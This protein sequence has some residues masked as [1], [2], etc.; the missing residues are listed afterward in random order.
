[1]KTTSTFVVARKQQEIRKN[2]HTVNSF[3]IQ[4]R[5]RSI[6]RNLLTKKP[7]LRL[8][9]L[10]LSDLNRGAIIWGDAIQ[11]KSNAFS[12]LID[13]AEAQ[14]IET[15]VYR[16]G[17][18][19]KVPYDYLDQSREKPIVLVI[20]DVEDIGTEGYR[21]LVTF[22][23]AY[24]RKAKV[25]PVIGINSIASTSTD[26]E[27]FEFSCSVMSHIAFNCDEKTANFVSELCGNYSLGTKKLTSSVLTTLPDNLFYLF[28]AGHNHPILGEIK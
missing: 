27:L 24:A 22:N 13:S 20:E 16:K 25:W 11:E 6:R 26:K 7:F 8:G 19:F 12:K 9:K 5:F 2:C 15:V 1:M 23:I 17:Y 14:G 3:S 18:A 28:T 10:P 21:Q 4:D